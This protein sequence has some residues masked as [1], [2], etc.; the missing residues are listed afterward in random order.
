MNPDHEIVHQ[1]R[2]IVGLLWWVSLWLF[3]IALNTCSIK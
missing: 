2:R 1:L 3:F